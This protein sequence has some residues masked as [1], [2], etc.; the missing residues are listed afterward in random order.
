MTVENPKV[1]LVMGATGTRKTSFINTVSGSN[2]AVPKRGDLD[3]C[4]ANVQK[5][6]PFKFGGHNVVLVDTPGFGFS[7]HENVVGTDQEVLKR[8]AD[9]LCTEYA[10]KVQLSGVI[11]MHPFP[12]VRIQ[13]TVKH[14][15][16][17]FSELCGPDVFD[18]V[19]IVITPSD[20][21]EEE[22]KLES[23]K[24]C[25][26]ADVS[27]AGGRILVET[28]DTFSVTRNY[29]LTSLNEKPVFLKIQREMG[30]QNMSLKDTSAGRVLS[31]TQKKDEKSH[32]ISWKKF[33]RG[34]WRIDV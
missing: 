28:D 16:G 1:I 9:F 33:R 10:K 7:G 2:F 14:Y 3:S 18:H 27:E 25:T 5:T 22:E 19:T 20:S 8:I 32:R 6:E 34:F 12:E 31:G 17:I 24:K 29:L 30:D 23:L 15:F 26:F 4:T 11:Y 13:R 21:G